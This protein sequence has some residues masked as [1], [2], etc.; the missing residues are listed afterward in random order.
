[1]GVPLVR[2]DPT[3]LTQSWKAPNY[4]VVDL[5]AMYS[6]PL[7]VDGMKAEVFLHVFNLLDN[8]YLQDAVDNS[9][10]NAFDSNHTADDAEVFFGLPRNVNAGFRLR[11]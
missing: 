2:T 9:R 11:F 5:N 8:V 4:G 3:D 6:I 10:Y 1:L 7:K